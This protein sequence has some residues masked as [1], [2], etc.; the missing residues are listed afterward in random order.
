MTA[1]M[2]GWRKPGGVDWSELGQGDLNAR[3]IISAFAGAAM[4]VKALLAAGASP[5]AADDDGVTALMAAADGGSAMCIEELGG[6]SD[7]GAID[8]AGKMALHW[9][10]G[11]E[12]WSILGLRR[13]LA[14]G[15]AARHQD[16]EGNTAL[17][18][19]CVDKPRD[20]VELLLERSDAMARN[21][22]GHSALDVAKKH[23][24]AK[25]IEILAAAEAVALERAQLEQSAAATATATHAMR[26]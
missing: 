25:L 17:I 26:L 13:L 3:L 24:N 2:R 4:A 14:N 21:A 15:A 19:A 23:K 18:T 9:A 22:Q 12:Q 11:S 1:N 20:F 7:H 8:Q 10:A 16:N 6:V 5:L